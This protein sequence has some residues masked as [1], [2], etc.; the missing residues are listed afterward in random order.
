MHLI[1]TAVLVADGALGP[2]L[3]LL[4]PSLWFLDDLLKSGAGFQSAYLERGADINSV[5]RYHVLWLR[6]LSRNQLKVSRAERDALA[7]RSERAGWISTPWSPP[8]WTPDL[9]SGLCLGFAMLTQDT[10]ADEAFMSVH[11]ARH[12]FRIVRSARS[13]HSVSTEECRSHRGI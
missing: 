6:C 8:P 13:S 9:G 12:H 3:L 2:R 5:P 7:R 10:V 11:N 1:G 4:L